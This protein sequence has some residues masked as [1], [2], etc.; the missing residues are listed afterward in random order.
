MK[1]KNEKGSPEVEG[2]II[3]TLLKFSFPQGELPFR[4]KS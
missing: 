4:Q 3:G 2:Y 1:E